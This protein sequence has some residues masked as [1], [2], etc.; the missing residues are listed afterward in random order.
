[1]E[2]MVALASG[3]KITL[4]FVAPG[5]DA[6][7][8][9]HFWNVFAEGV[10][11]QR[12]D[13]HQEAFFHV[14]ALQSKMEAGLQVRVDANQPPI[15]RYIYRDP[16]TNSE[17]LLE[18]G[19][20]KMFY[21][22][23]SLK[24]I[25]DVKFLQY[26][27]QTKRLNLN[28]DKD[29]QDRVRDNTAYAFEY[30]AHSTITVLGKYL[31]VLIDDLEPEDLQQTDDQ[32]K[33]FDHLITFAASQDPCPLNLASCF[34]ATCAMQLEP[35]KKFYKENLRLT[36]FSAATPQQ[37]GAFLLSQFQ[38]APRDVH[39]A[40][41]PL[42]IEQLQREN[43]RTDAVLQP[44]HLSTVTALAMLAKRSEVTFQS[45]NDLLQIFAHD[46]EV[47]RYRSAVLVAEAFFQKNPGWQDRYENDPTF[48]VLSG[49]H[50]ASLLG[51]TPA[52]QDPFLDVCAAEPRLLTLGEHVASLPHVTREDF[53]EILD[54]I[55]LFQMFAGRKTPE[56]QNNPVA[57]QLW[58][59]VV[60]DNNLPLDDLEGAVSGVISAHPHRHRG[61]LQA[62]IET[63]R[64]ATGTGINKAKR[65]VTAYLIGQGIDRRW[66]SDLLKYNDLPAVGT[67]Q[68]AQLEGILQDL[69]AA[70]D[71]L[72]TPRAAPIPT[73]AATAAAPE[74]PAPPATESIP[75]APLPSSSP[76]EQK[77]YRQQVRQAFALALDVHG[78]S[79]PW[80]PQA[81][82]MAQTLNRLNRD[83]NRDTNPDA[84]LTGVDLLAAWRGKNAHTAVGRVIQA[85]VATDGTAA[86]KDDLHDRLRA[87]RP[88]TAT[89]SDA[90]FQALLT[91]LA[92]HYRTVPEEALRV[93]LLPDQPALVPTAAE[94]AL[95]T[96]F[97][98]TPAGLR[99]AVFILNPLTFN[100]EAL[101]QS[102]DAIT[103]L[104]PVDLDTDACVTRLNR[105]LTD[106]AAAT[107]VAF[108]AFRHDRTAGVE[109]LRARETLGDL[110]PA[111]ADAEGAPLDL[112]TNTAAPE[113]QRQRLVFAAI[114]QG[115]DDGVLTLPDQDGGQVFSGAS[116]VA[117]VATPEAAADPEA[118]AALFSAQ[119][120]REDMRTRL[121]TT[122]LNPLLGNRQPE[123]VLDATAARLNALHGDSVFSRAALQDVLRGRLA[124]DAPVMQVLDVIFETCTADEL[125][126]CRVSFA[127]P[128]V[129]A[130]LN[131]IAFTLTYPRADAPA[132][133]LHLFNPHHADIGVT[134]MLARAGTHRQ[135]ATPQVYEA[136]HD[137]LTGAR[138]DI[139]NLPQAT[140]AALTGFVLDL[141]QNSNA[142]PDYSLV[143]FEGR[144]LRSELPI[145]YVLPP[146]Q[147]A[148]DTEYLD[149]VLALAA[150]FAQ[151]LS[152]GT[153]LS[154]GT[155]LP[156]GTAGAVALL[157]ENQQQALTA[158]CTEAQVS[159]TALG[160]HIRL[161]HA[162]N[163][164]HLAADAQPAFTG[165]L[166]H[167]DLADLY[168]LAAER[169]HPVADAATET[170][171]FEDY[172]A[173]WL[174]YQ[175]FSPT[176][177]DD[178][179]IRRDH[180]VYVQE[181][182]AAHLL[183]WVP[184]SQLNTRAPDLT[185]GDFRFIHAALVQKEPRWQNPATLAEALTVDGTPTYAVSTLKT[186]LLG[187]TA[188]HGEHLEPWRAE[189]VF[190]LAVR[191]LGGDWW[192]DLPSWQAAV[193]VAAPRIPALETTPEAIPEAT[194]ETGQ[195][196]ATAAATILPPAA[197]QIVAP[198]VAAPL[199]RR[200][201]TRDEAAT[202]ATTLLRQ[203]VGQGYNLAALPAQTLI[204]VAPRVVQH[205]KEQKIR[206]KHAIVD[207]TALFCEAIH[208]AW[209]QG[210]PVLISQALS[211]SDNLFHDG[212]QPPHTRFHIIV[213]MPESG[214][215]MIANP[216]NPYL[217]FVVRRTP[218][219]YRNAH[220][221]RETD[222][223]AFLAQP[224]RIVTAYPIAE[225]TRDI[226]RPLAA[227][228]AAIACYQEALPE[229]EKDP[230]V[231]NRRTVFGALRTVA[232]L[233]PNDQ[234][235]R[236]GF[237]VSA[238]MTVE[239]DT[240]VIA[241]DI[242]PTLGALF[243][244]DL[245]NRKL[246]GDARFLV[247]KGLPAG[248]YN[249]DWTPATSQTRQTESTGSATP[250]AWM[251]A[252]VQ[253]SQ[254]QPR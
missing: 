60:R 1:M 103:A 70:P 249:G 253:Q 33:L 206:E 72:T 67:P 92:L 94:Q 174:G 11:P 141:A 240:L 229:T 81:E 138:L 5:P 16:K 200:A 89:I 99:P 47:A 187:Q 20:N 118:L 59:Q 209:H 2:S 180:T 169:L 32:K 251:V 133:A 188:R 144:R 152:Q 247:T 214:Q 93:T 147:N 121:L 146:E 167:R 58:E 130:A 14:L 124:S 219:D 166:T 137:L 161:R 139:T 23:F 35:V 127:H 34:V 9:P 198:S 43:I 172:F 40:A 21:D 159:E 113:T 10:F 134:E 154:E 6:Y 143:Q 91:A 222:I 27:T 122:L 29:F 75:P 116:A 196:P 88:T 208:A 207:P 64:A 114:L 126:A 178:T 105:L 215:S 39:A 233:S 170:P 53:H 218:K 190:A 96:R 66:A 165:N 235:K 102:L 145:S 51:L 97:L 232:L 245:L 244:Q 100:P 246:P 230:A 111:S 238:F 171:P 55:R 37:I 86:A 54:R 84:G 87:A 129:R 17:M 234:K 76:E 183:R 149:T 44:A 168:R 79:Q 184:P 24:N 119:L 173:A 73:A 115:L 136:L 176:R 157:A 212:N 110:F 135:L 25:I 192:Q 179:F 112:L 248:R 42:V 38:R 41:L 108:Y 224:F 182:L 82:L 26:D 128:D 77:I 117:P 254:K 36:D 163:A 181:F 211:G 62:I 186:L 28:T 7:R 177:Q 61:F 237:E 48:R 104:L 213:P 201:R 241:K 83:T 150:D 239:G 12:P 65:E 101:D 220:D 80:L 125:A 46:T 189:R 142:T 148:E 217:D 193:P 210:A 227:Y 156:D 195:T 85:L 140:R 63:H 45:A 50:L 74:Q 3:K 242:S 236:F 203:Q 52:E 15:L 226:L 155:G 202:F 194:P 69:L 107:A 31:G 90:E 56:G 250:P 4:R 68:H 185:W 98:E 204:G 151:G 197:T 57:A 95:T 228:P 18:I 175:A 216:Q 158:L 71:R 22:I 231:L 225:G 243:H 131:R 160:N 49:L 199:Q 109:L 123:D 205:S 30:Y 221:F 252:A 164:L 132:D 120:Y 191:E 106:P 19:D 153:G 13:D 223:R 78:R 8:P 162:Q